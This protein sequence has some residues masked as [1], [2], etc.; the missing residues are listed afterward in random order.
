VEHLVPV[1]QV[2]GQ[3]VDRHRSLPTSS[4]VPRSCSTRRT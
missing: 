2:D 1:F 4:G 3:G